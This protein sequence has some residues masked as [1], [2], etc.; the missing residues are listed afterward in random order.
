MVSKRRDA[1]YRSGTR[2][3]GIKTRAWRNA[4]GGCLSGTEVRKITGHLTANHA[5]RLT[6]DLTLQRELA[7]LLAT[8]RLE[9]GEQ[10]GRTRQLLGVDRTQI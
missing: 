8:F 2:C 6:M 4:A 5:N 1:P 3:G 9:D 7:Q 10:S